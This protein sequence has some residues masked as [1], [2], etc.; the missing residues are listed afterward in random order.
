[1]PTISAQNAINWHP[2]A[3]EAAKKPFV[4]TFSPGLRSQNCCC[5]T[6]K[7]W[8]TDTSRLLPR[9]G[10]HFCGTGIPDQKLFYAESTLGTISRNF[11][12]F[13]TVALANDFVRA[14][15]FFLPAETPSSRWTTVST[16]VKAGQGSSSD[17][18]YRRRFTCLEQLLIAFRF[19]EVLPEPLRYE[20]VRALKRQ[21]RLRSKVSCF[22]N[23]I[24][25]AL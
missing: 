14:R 15:P 17:A 12:R 23:L 19:W 10:D 21:V 3:A 20:K 16:P 8:S 6:R 22:L 13:L 18:N 11:M 4:K 25:K 9:I 7:S 2:L 5:C 24:S 1:M